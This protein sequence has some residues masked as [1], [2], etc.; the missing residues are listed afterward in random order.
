M[1]IFFFYYYMSAKEIF[2]FKKDEI[3]KISLK[4]LLS[5]VVTG[6]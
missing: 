2:K 5:M 6:L 3:D 1:V 4:E